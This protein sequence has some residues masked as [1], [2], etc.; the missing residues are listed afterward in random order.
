MDGYDDLRLVLLALRAGLVDPARLAEVGLGWSPGGPTPF[1]QYLADR[2][3]VDPA[4]L[5]ALEAGAPTA[6]S[7]PSVRPA[8]GGTPSFA[9]PGPTPTWSPPPFDPAADTQSYSSRGPVAAASLPT[10]RADRYEVIELYRTGGLGQVWRARD[11][12]VG[13]EV[14]LKTLRPDRADGLDLRARFVREART[15]GQLEHPCVVP[16]YD[17]LEGADGRPRY[18]MRFVA[19]RTL[20]EAVADY[21]A[22][23]ADGKAGPLDLAAL[24]D[25]FVA[26]CRAV[27]FAH[28][29]GVLHRDLKGQNVVL[30]D[31]GEV[32]LL[33]WGLAKS[34]AEADGGGEPLPAFDSADPTQ[35]TATGGVVGTPAYMA[36]EVAVGGPATKASDVYGL[37]AVLYTV[38]TGQPPYD[39]S[40]P[41]EVLERVKA[42]EPPPPRAV[43]PS[44]PPPLEAICRQ[45]M[46]RDPAARYGSADGLATDVRR[47][48]ADEPVSAYRD[49]W[50]VRAT[51]W[52][53]RHRTPV[54]AAAVFL[55]TAVVALA[56]STALVW[57]EERRTA[58]QKL[59][60][61][62]HSD[63]LAGLTG[64]L[65]DIAEAGLV[66]VPESEPAR[67]A[68]L[69]AALDTYHG[70]LADR[71]ADPAV[72]S[73]VGMLHRYRA[74]LLRL[75]DRVDDAEADYREAIALLRPPADAL[76]DP[77]R[78]ARFT[79]ARV[80]YA[81]LLARAGR[82]REAV[83]LLTEEAQAVSGPRMVAYV[84]VNLAEVEADRGRWGEAGRLARLA[85]IEYRAFG[86]LPAEY[87]H[88]Y[89][90]VFQALAERIAAAADRAGGRHREAAAALAA[91]IDRLTRLAAAPTPG[92]IPDDVRNALGLCLVEQAQA[93]AADDRVAADGAAGRAAGLW[94]E[95]AVRHPLIKDYRAGAAQARRV[96][97]RIR[98][99]AGR[100]AD[101][102]A[103]LTAARTTLERVTADAPH[104][105]QFAEYLAGTHVGL[106]LVA[107]ADRDPAGAAAEYEKAVKILRP[108]AD[109]SPENAAV[110]ESLA[111]AEREL[112]G[113]DRR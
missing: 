102:K 35:P 17:L 106:G 43:E 61:E 105:V 84:R 107:R 62:Q 100:T 8:G 49:P 76:P 79:E 99:D 33:D 34:A 54:A 96:R 46:A 21:H 3:L 24:L 60:A 15:T 41:W 81:I 53:R 109:R 30:G 2:G 23:R 36:P 29:K 48:L 71:P 25:A 59:K 72:R 113:G 11:T 91:P 108:V 4:Q 69:T 77:A 87:R 64:R 112:A 38:L 80:D 98:L 74:N 40:G 101:A 92:L 10:G 9:G 28:A 26:V 89:D 52:A 20:S 5:S 55:L 47:W 90:P 67:T 1:R 32:F 50:G 83:D 70:I 39:G 65:I 31:Y 68:L 16:L 27:A 95:L 45:A 63:A 51:R 44:V 22:R 82:L 66:P 56:A 7:T 6:V 86:D 93:L 58:E 94:D 37:G 78:A 85:A 110:R 88:P 73:Q 14:A 19:G 97:G 104:R 12:A 18:V 75:T 42:G 13:R 111:E 103:D 57:R